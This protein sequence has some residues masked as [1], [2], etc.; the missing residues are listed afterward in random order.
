MKEI[1]EILKPY[2]EYL[3]STEKQVLEIT[4]ECGETLPWE[5]KI[6]GCPYLTSEAD[7]PRDKD[8][9]PMMFLAQINL[10][11]MP[12]LE[13][14]PE[15][16]LLQ[17]YV[18]DDDNYGG[19]SPCR[20]IYIPEYEKDASKLLSKNPFEDGYMGMPPFE[21]E[22]KM[23]FAPKTMFICTE[24]QE[25]QDKFRQKVSD[26]IWDVLTEVCYPEG[27]LVGGYPL[28]VQQAPEYYDSGEYD[29]L[30]LQLDCDDECGIMFGD[31]GSCF[32]LIPKENLKKRNFDNVE[33]GWQCC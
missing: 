25:F 26:E 1:P 5:S 22:G 24:C 13:D 7:Y 21:C 18:G 29:T 28:F 15:H 11:D 19:D 12:H 9:R 32:F 6:G 14:Y 20:V 33:Y 31:A 3:R 8:G 23:T 30:L 10:D 4:F 27:S 2:E 17:F 16:G